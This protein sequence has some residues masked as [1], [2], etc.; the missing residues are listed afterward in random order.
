MKGLVP[1]KYQRTNV[2]SMSDG[3]TNQG[4]NDLEKSCC[5]YYFSLFL[6]LITS[7]CSGK[8]ALTHCPTPQPLPWKSYSGRIK[9][10][11]WKTAEIAPS[12]FNLL[13]ASSPSLSI[14]RG[15]CLRKGLTDWLEWSIFYG[16]RG[17]LQAC[18]K[19]H[20]V[21]VITLL[22]IGKSFK[23]TVL[24][25]CVGVCTFARRNPI[26]EYCSLWHCSFHSW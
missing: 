5:F 17:L 18:S 8:S 25:E 2:R 10:L 16:E 26:L 20:P 7:C 14:Q 21:V 6:G 11:T 1:L 22:W 12:M 23:V 9:D 3:T 13:L 19:L 24:H 4:L 15:C